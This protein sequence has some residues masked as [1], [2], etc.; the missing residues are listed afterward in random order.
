MDRGNEGSYQNEVFA[1][2]TDQGQDIR[3]RYPF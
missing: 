1:L 3:E 2:R